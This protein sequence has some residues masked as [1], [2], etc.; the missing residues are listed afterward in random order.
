LSN[1]KN[2]NKNIQNLSIWGI[3]FFAI[4]ISYYLWDD[5][6]VSMSK[7]KF[8]YII[9]DNNSITIEKSK[10]GHFYLPLTINDLQIIFLV[11][12]G[13]SRSLLSRKDFKL[14]KDGNI[15]LPTETI[16]ETANGIVI[17]KEIIFQNVKVFES[18]LGEISFLVATKNFKGPRISLLGLDLLNNKFKYEITNNYLKLQLIP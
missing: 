18:D 8:N 14:V 15:F 7:E 11:D 3:I 4:L 13:A 12:T 16:L 10:D 2:L 1:K 9:E 5:L 17:A 6:K